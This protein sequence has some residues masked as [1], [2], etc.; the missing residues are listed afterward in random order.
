M[1]TNPVILSW[2]GAVDARLW[3]AV[4]AGAF[5][6]SGWLVNGWQNRRA[7]SLLRAERL[8][9]VHRA[10]YAEIGTKLTNLIGPDTLAQQAD[11]M[12]ARMQ[13]D[14][15]F[16]P[17]ISHEHG[18]YVFNSVITDIS[19]LPRRTIDPIVAYYS[20]IK[21]LNAH[22]E[23]MRGK[24]FLTM[25]QDRRIAMYNDYMSMKQQLLQFGLYANAM[26]KAYADG[27]NDAADR[28]SGQFNSR[29]GGGRS[30]RSQGS[31]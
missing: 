17:F 21:T 22:A 6:S 2:L 20:Q 27:G 3:Q 10:I 18:D 7:A 8:R 14:P 15:D 26:I 5:L 28:V 11:A 13:N 19:V 4:I 25:D 12:R 24:R 29:R 30:D 31:A 23:D 1:S 9:D 16:I